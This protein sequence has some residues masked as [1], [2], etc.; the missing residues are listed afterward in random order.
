MAKCLSSLFVAIFL[1]QVFASAQVI[2]GFPGDSTTI[3]FM[4]G[5]MPNV[6]PDTAAKQLWKIGHSTKT[7]FG[8]NSSGQMTMMTDTAKPYP[9]NAN[10]WFIIK[11]FSLY[12]IVDFWHKYQ[13]RAGHDGGIVEFSMDGGTSWQ[14]VKGECNEDGSKGRGILTTNFYSKTDTLLTGEPAFTGAR[15]STQFSRL[16]FWGGYAVSPPS[17][18]GCS[19]DWPYDF[20]VRFR[21]VSDSAADTL[22]GWMIDSIKVEHDLYPG[23]VAEIIKPGSLLT[24]PNPSYNSLFI[25][26]ALDN[27]ARFNLEIYNGLGQSIMKL[28]YKQSLDLAGYPKGLYFYRVSNGQEYYTGRLLVE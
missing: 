27:E 24:H 23:G 18:S 21:F 28:P 5:T 6:S 26:P 14:N 13:T 25:F 22:A 3:T 12:V 15:D 8:V 10:N 16:Q 20:Q 2:D 19:F 17:G 9:V 7:F 11:G 1:M 4:S